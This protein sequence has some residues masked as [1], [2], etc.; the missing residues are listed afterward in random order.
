M[1][2]GERWSD[3]ER[4]LADRFLKDIEPLLQQI[5]RLKDFRGGRLPFDTN[6][7]LQSFDKYELTYPRTAI[8]LKSLQ[9]MAPSDGRQHGIAA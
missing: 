8:K 5:D 7:N 6:F 4:A 2:L 3:A 1:P 9:V